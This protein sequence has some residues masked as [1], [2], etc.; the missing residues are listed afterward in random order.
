MGQPAE[1]NRSQ[2]W[3]RVFLKVITIAGYY[4]VWWSA[5]DVVNGYATDPV[6]TIRLTSP[7]SVFPQ[8]IQPWTAVVYIAGGLIFPSIIFLYHLK[9]WSGIASAMVRITATTV[10]SFSVYLAW[11]IS[12]VRPVFAGET[13]GERLML[14]VFS[15]DKPAN[16]FPSSHVFFAVLG[17]LQVYS[18]GAGRVARWFW[19]SFATAVCVSTV[20]SGQHYFIDVPGGIIVALLGYIIGGLLIPTVQP[21]TTPLT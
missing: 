20:T 11:P 10:L 16:C 5:Y 19:L 3:F 21:A 7:A 15:V 18:S 9:T 13:L 14:W 6:R 8:I 12:I 1:P 4:L 17:A 2:V